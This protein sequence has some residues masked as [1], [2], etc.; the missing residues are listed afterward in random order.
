[1][2]FYLVEYPDGGWSVTKDYTG[3]E[4]TWTRF[5]WNGGVV[6]VEEI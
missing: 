1:M 2:I 6:T 4:G 3:G 5:T